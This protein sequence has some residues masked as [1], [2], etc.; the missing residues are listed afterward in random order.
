MQ[1][2]RQR[3]FRC[4]TAKPT[5]GKTPNGV[6]ALYWPDFRSSKKAKVELRKLSRTGLGISDFPCVLPRE[7]LSSFRRPPPPVRGVSEFRGAR[8]DLGRIYG[9][10]PTG[11]SGSS[12]C[13][14]D[15]PQNLLDGLRAAS[16]SCWPRALQFSLRFNTRHPL[17]QFNNTRP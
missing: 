7:G 15:R 10:R 12:T 1:A 17:H 14:P 13:R 6:Y 9:G 4:L 16:A 5:H 8:S 11:I 3:V 2:D